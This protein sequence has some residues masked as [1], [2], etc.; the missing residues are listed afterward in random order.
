[1]QQ[2]RSSGSPGMMAILQPKIVLSP[3]FWSIFY[4]Q[5]PIFIEVDTFSPYHEWKAR[6][7]WSVSF[8]IMKED[9]SFHSCYTQSIGQN[10]TWTLRLQRIIGNN[11]VFKQQTHASICFTPGEKRTIFIGGQLEVSHSDTGSHGGEILLIFIC[12]ILNKKLCSMYFAHAK[13]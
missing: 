13:C 5:M 7:V 6:R 4:L 1:M 11:A 10:Y 12:G 9:R 8:Q 2:S 3:R